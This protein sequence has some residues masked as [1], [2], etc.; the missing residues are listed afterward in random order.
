MIYAIEIP[1]ELGEA[2]KAFN[3][4]EEGAFRLSVKNPD[5]KGGVPGG[6]PTG[7]RE[8]AEFSQE[9]ELFSIL[10]LSTTFAQV[11]LLYDVFAVKDS[12]GSLRWHPLTPPSFLNYKN[13]ELIFIATHPGDLPDIAGEE[14]IHDLEEIADE[15]DVEALGEEQKEE[16][17]EEVIKSIWEM[18]KA[19]GKDKTVVGG[20]VAVTGEWE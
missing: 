14:I 3:L 20:D 8:K 1:H 11:D 17:E 16:V 5:V 13:A 4:R 9:C 18:L 2:Q 7:L 6:P 15:G 12:M 19:R 10:G